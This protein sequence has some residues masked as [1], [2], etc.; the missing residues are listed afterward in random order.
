MPGT[1][2]G[3]IAKPHPTKFLTQQVTVLQ[4][5]FVSE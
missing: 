3:G 2:M 4:S 5:G 1:F